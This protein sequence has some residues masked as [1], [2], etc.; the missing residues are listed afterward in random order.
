MES[1]ALEISFW[2][3]NGERFANISYALHGNTLTLIYTKD[4]TEHA[5]YPVSLVSTT[6]PKG[7]RRYWFKCP[8]RGCGRMV[9]KLYLP[10]GALYFGCRK[11]YNLTYESCNES[12]KFDGLYRLLAGNIGTSFDRIKEVMREK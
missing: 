1:R 6:Q 5:N 12:H 2:S 9:E 7:G 10:N 8:L 4:K 3:R 11:C